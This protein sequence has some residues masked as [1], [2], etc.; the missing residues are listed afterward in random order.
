MKATVITSHGGLEVF[1]YTE[2]PTPT[3]GPKDVL[4]RVKACALNHLDIWTRQGM[5][6]VAIPMPHILGC[7]VAGIVER[8]GERVR[9]VKV[10]QRVIIAP[11]QPCGKCAW[12]KRGR[13]SLCREFR[14][15]GFQT[16]GGYAEYVAAESRHVIPISGKWSFEEWAAVPLVFLTA[17]HMLMTR[18]GLQRGETVLIQAA[19][20]GVG[21]AAIQIA[22]WAGARVI[23]TAGSDAKLQRAKALGAHEAI[24]Y[25]AEDVTERVK[26]LT[27]GRGADVSFEHIGPQTWNASLKSLGRGGRLVTCGATTGP[28]V[29][30]D[31]RF[32]YTRE[33]SVAG[34]YMG[35]RQEL[36]RVLKLVAAG[37]LKPVVDSVF[38]LRDAAKAHEKM[39]SRD[40]FGKIILTP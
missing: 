9:N 10:G 3:V 19:G 25:T 27:D 21:S 16:D 34:C 24:N 17:W 26:A 4:V 15:L 35:G 6:G 38:P 33:L 37:K 13:D 1:Q 23:T 14:I 29:E 2:R 11:G 12:C 40:H 36:E 22:R 5:P 18:A 8:V 28:K 31:L 20:S 30:L 7:D 39:L 32:F